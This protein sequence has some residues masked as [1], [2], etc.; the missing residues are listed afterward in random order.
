MSY[1]RGRFLKNCL[2]SIKR[3][4][5]MCKATIVDDGST[6][7][8]TIQVI[9]A[10]KKDLQFHVINMQEDASNQKHGGLYANMQWVL[11]NG[12]SE[13][14]ILF[15]QDDT[16]LVRVIDK[17]DLDYID[18]YFAVARN[19]AFLHPAFLKQASRTRIASITLSEN[20]PAYVASFE[21]A[22]A[23][24]S[25]ICI[26]HRG[27]LKEMGFRLANTERGNGAAA[28][29]VFA[30][31]GHMIHP[32]VA[33]LPFVPNYRG[34]RETMT[35]R[36]TRKIGTIGYFP[37]ET[38]NVDQVDQLK[39][40]D[41]KVLPIAEN[42]LNPRGLGERHK[43]WRHDPVDQKDWIRK[44]GRYEQRAVRFLQKLKLWG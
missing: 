12:A 20:F 14:K 24:F 7:E 18:R 41:L 42:F 17:E 4:A 6:D 16:Q 26:V 23:Y 36:L 29:D 13:E 19:V 3:C 34:K 10:A 33:W 40:R 22:V 39:S 35:I 37:F 30:P 2:D 5:P 32:F 43:P 25:A 1:N 21:R 9:Q 8:E 11:D 27:R 44:L 28:K 15:V 31:M 38:M